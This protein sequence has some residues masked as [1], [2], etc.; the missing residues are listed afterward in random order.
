MSRISLSDIAIQREAPDLKERS[1]IGLSKSRLENY[2]SGLG[3]REGNLL[4]L[5]DNTIRNSLQFT[6]EQEES[7]KLIEEEQKAENFRNRFFT[8]DY[9]EELDYYAKQAGLESQGKIYFSPNDTIETGYMNYFEASDAGSMYGG[10]FELMQTNAATLR[11]KTQMMGSDAL[12]KTS[13]AW[14]KIQSDV[15]TTSEDKTY[16]D[17]QLRNSNNWER[18][19]NIDSAESLAQTADYYISPIVETASKIGEAFVG[20]AGA[21]SQPYARG[22][23]IAAG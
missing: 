9:D 17:R 22:S 12:L 19:V 14:N 3:A 11:T 15:G 18:W 6:A 2:K 8:K 7:K 4:S 23:G 5:I 16:Y 21:M 1:E 20:Q 13:K 10:S